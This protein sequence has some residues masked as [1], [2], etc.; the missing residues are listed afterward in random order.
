M[1][2]PS[3]VKIA[4]Q[5]KHSHRYEQNPMEEAFALEWQDQCANGANLEYLLS[6]DNRPNVVDLRDQTTAN[7]V[8]QWL[9]SPVGQSFLTSVMAKKGSERFLEYLVGDPSIR[10][11]LKKLLK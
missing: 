5:G 6:S 4:Y 8:I 7:T 10:E 1:S 9:G 2:K 11:K 3:L